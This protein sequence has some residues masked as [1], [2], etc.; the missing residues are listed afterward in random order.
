MVLQ[1]LIKMSLKVRH[2]SSNRLEFVVCSF[3]SK[4][5][6]RPLAVVSTTYIFVHFLKKELL[7]QTFKKH[8]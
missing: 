1:L 2:T 6:F 7:T 3:I 5:K 4:Y 8:Y